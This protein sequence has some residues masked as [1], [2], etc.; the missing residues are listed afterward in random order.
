MQ[1]VAAASLLELTPLRRALPKDIADEVSFL[2]HNAVA[3]QS[4]M[5]NLAEMGAKDASEAAYVHAGMIVLALQRLLPGVDVN[6]LGPPTIEQR[7]AI[8]TQPTN[9]TGGDWRQAHREFTNFWKLRRHGAAGAGG[10]RGR[11]AVSDAE[12]QSLDTI[13]IEDRWFVRRL[14]AIR[15]RQLLGLVRAMDDAVNNTS[16]ILLIRAGRKKLLFPG[17]AQWENWEHALTQHARELRDV[18]LYKAGH[19]GS[20]AGTPRALWNLFRKRS[21]RKTD[22]SRL[23]TVIWAPAGNTHGT[24]ESDTDYPSEKLL[25]ALKKFSTVRS[26]QEL[27]GSNSIVL[28]LE[29]DLT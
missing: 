8:A 15:G 26:T 7:A 6:I 29:I 20:L 3:D 11:A 13:P 28:K 1:T 5:Q 10:E 22:A 16:V 14:R 12:T 18:D 21:S 17:D 23:H 19:H 27:D 2:G 25:R 24:R 4:A 9:R